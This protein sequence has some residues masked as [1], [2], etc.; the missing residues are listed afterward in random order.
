MPSQPLCIE[1]T[2]DQSM[3]TGGARILGCLRMSDAPVRNLMQRSLLS[4]LAG[5]LPARTRE[6][7]GSVTVALRAR[8]LR[9]WSAGGAGQLAIPGARARTAAGPATTAAAWPGS[10]ACTC[11][12]QRKTGHG[13]RQ[14]S[15]AAAWQRAGERRLA[16]R[17][18][19]RWT[20][21]HARV[22]QA[23]Q[24]VWLRA[25]PQD[26]CSMRRAGPARAF[27]GGVAW[28]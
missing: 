18:S 4:S 8:Q 3:R 22:V 26:D 27:L 15:A 1:V 7:P 20:M 25:Q 13:R 19:P 5:L 23:T 24:A 16:K 17:R 28:L 2:N 10:A 9:H 12:L 21:A 11:S 6:P 14:G